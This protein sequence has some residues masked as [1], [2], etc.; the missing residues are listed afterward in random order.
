MVG[1]GPLPPRAL[2]PAAAPCPFCDLDRA[3][4]GPARGDTG[5]SRVCLQAG[6]R[7]QELGVQVTWLEKARLLGQ[8]SPVLL[9][10]STWLLA[11]ATG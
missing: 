3:V 5:H 8:V 10:A 4:P 7:H 9:L 6:S 2:R 1:S 11:R